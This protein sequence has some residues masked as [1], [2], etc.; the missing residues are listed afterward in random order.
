MTS[1]LATSESPPPPTLSKFGPAAIDR[2]INR[3]LQEAIPGQERVAILD[4]KLTSAGEERLLSGVV[5]GNLG[6]GWG[7]ALGGVVD[8]ND[9]RDWE[10]EAVVRKSW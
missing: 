1:K 10:V 2:V 9:K 3:Q 5:A 6:H 8:M 4:I 7:A